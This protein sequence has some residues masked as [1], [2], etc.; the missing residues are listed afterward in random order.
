MT[1]GTRMDIITL[2]PENIESEHICC[3]IA[4]NNDCQ[5]MSKK[6]WLRDRFDDGLVFKKCDV[7]GKCFIEYIPAENAWVPIKADGYMYI[8]CLWVA[9]QYKGKG[10]SNLLLEACIDDSKAKGMK[11]LVILSSPKKKPFLSD[12][13][14]LKYKGFVKVDEAEP[15]FD[16]YYL[17]FSE[18]SSVPAFMEQVKHPLIEEHG[19]VL[20]Y[21][22]QCPYIAK[23]VPLLQNVAIENGSTLKVIH[24]ETSKQAKNA[25]VASTTFALFHDGK[26]ITNEILSE[27]KFEKMI[28]SC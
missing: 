19:Y 10:L 3:A 4:N 9:G 5:V 15:F 23:Y 17:P 25:P 2:T 26:F 6:S 14:Y 1:W 13:K 7:R 22:N 24:I 28:T 21:T 18:N 11:G 8:D 27:K 16:L 20:Y 12:P